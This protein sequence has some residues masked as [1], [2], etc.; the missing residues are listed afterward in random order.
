MLL[1]LCG[2]PVASHIYGILMRVR[3]SYKH[4]SAYVSIRQ[5]TSAYVSIRQHT[6]AYVSIR[7]IYGIL[8]RVRDSYELLLRQYLYFCTSKASKLS[9]RPAPDARRRRFRVIYWRLPR[10]LCIRKKNNLASSIDAFNGRSA[11][12]ILVPNVRYFST[13][14]CVS[15]YQLCLPW[16]ESS[17]QLS[18]SGRL[19][20]TPPH[21]RSLSHAQSGL[22]GAPT[23]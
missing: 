11:L 1:D 15:T 5:H 18:E 13:K 2:I 8:V 21:T 19:R 7:H 20:G 3:D 14:P 4:T 6:S 22:A 16:A 10:P 23:R 9:T 12:D 17:S